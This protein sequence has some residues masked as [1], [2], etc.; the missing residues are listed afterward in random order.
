MAKFTKFFVNTKTGKVETIGATKVT[1]LDLRGN[2]LRVGSPT[3]PGT[4]ANFFVSGNLRSKLDNTGS[5]AVF[6][7]DVIV[8]G[9][10]TANLGLSGSLTNLSDGT[11][12]LVAGDNVTI[13]SSSN[14]NITI[15]GTSVS[16]GVI[17]KDLLSRESA[18]GTQTYTL[19]QAPDDGAATQVFVNGVLMLSASHGLTN[20]YDYNAGTNQIAFVSAPD[21][22]SI[23][24]AVY[25]TG[26]SGGGGGGGAWTKAGSTVRLTEISDLVGVGTASPEAKFEISDTLD[27]NDDLNDPSDYQL[28][29][30]HGSQTNDKSAGIG[31]TVETVAENIGAAIIHNRDGDYSQG[32]LQFYT[33]NS[34]SDAADPDLAMTITNAQKVGIGTASPGAKLE[35]EVADADNS[36]GVL[37]DSD[38]TGAHYALEVDAESTSNPAAYIHGYG[39]HLEQDITSGYGLKVSRNIAEGGSNPLVDIHDD[40]T[41]NTQTTLKVAQDGSGDLVNFLTGT[42]E[43][44]TI[45]NSGQLGVGTTSPN[46]KITIEGALS[47]DELAASPGTTSGYGKVFVKS[48]DSKLYFKNDSGTEFDLTA[49]AT[50]GAPTDAEYVVLSTD[51]GLSA[52]RVLTPGNG[53][54]LVD[55]GSGAAVTISQSINRDDFAFATGELNLAAQVVKSASADSGI[56]DGASHTLTFAGGEGIDTSAAGST[57]TIA[58]ENASTSNKGITSFAAADFTVISGHTS[59]AD[60]VL[61]TVTGDAGSAT[62]SGHNLNFIGGTNVA[63]TATGDTVTITSSP[64]TAEF[65]KELLS[66]DSTEGA[67]EYTLSNTPAVADQIQVY[68]NGMLRLSGSGNDYVYDSGDNQIDF[69]TPPPSGSIIQAIYTTAGS[70]S[71]AD[72]FFN[73]T[74]VGS[75]FTT[76]AAAFIGGR[77]S[78]S[79]IDAPSDKGNDVFFFVSGTI[80][81]K[82]TANTGSAL[83]GGDVTVSGTTTSESGFSGSLTRLSNGTSFLASAGTITITTSSTG[84]VTISTL[85][86]AGTNFFSSPA[87]GKINTTGSIIFRGAQKTPTTPDEANDIGTDTFF[88]VSGTLGARGTSN[89]GSAVFGGD[90]IFSGA[91]V[92]ELGLSGSLTRLSDGT[93]YLAAGENI[94]ITSTSNGQ[95]TITSTGGGTGISHFSSTTAGSIFTTGAVAFVGG[96]SSP[97]AIDAPSDIGNDVFFFVSGTI[98]SHATSNTGSAVF[99]GDVVIS[100]ALYGGSPLVVGDGLI[101]TGAINSTLGLSGSLTRLADGTSYLAAGSNVTITSSSNGQ[102]TIASSGGGGSITVKENDGDP[103]VSSVTTISFDNA[104]VTDAGSNTVVISGT[105]GTAEDGSYEDGLFT[106][107]TNKTYTGVA[108]D[109]I[110]EVL[111]LLAPSPAPDLDDVNAFETGTGVSLSFGSSNSVAG[112]TNVAGS[113]GV[114]AAVDVNGSYAVLT[115]SNNI[116]LAAFNH[117]QS[118]SGDLNADVATSFSGESI[119]NFVSRSFGNAEQGFLHLEVNGT[120]IATA[121][122]SGTTSDTVRGVLA[123]GSGSGRYLNT[124][125]SGFT[126]LSITGSSINND[127]SEF[128]FFQHRTGRFLVSTSSQRSGWNYARVLHV[129]DGS[130]LQT[131]YLEW[132]NDSNS[133]ALAAS[134]NSIS[135]EMSGSVHLSGVEYFTS[136]NVR[137]KV[138]VSNAYRNVYDTN[139]ITFTTTNCTIDSQAKP[140]IAGGEDHTK[141]LHLTGVGPIAQTML[142]TGSVTASVNVTHPFKANLSTAGVAEV[143]SILMFNLSGSS[144]LNR[145]IF[146]AE[147]YRIQSGAF[148]TQ[149]DVTDA[150]NAWNSTK[151]MTASNGGHTNGL[152]F[153]SASL[154]SPL[155][156]IFSGDFRNSTDGGSIST[157]PSEN[158]NYSGLTGSNTFYRYFRNTTGATHYT[159]K[160]NISGSSSTIVASDAALDSGKIRVFLKVPTGSAGKTGWLDL[161]SGFSFG[162]FEDNDGCRDGTFDSSLNASNF[163][164]FGNQGVANNEYIC[165]RIEASSSWAGQVDEFEVIFG[166]GTGTTQTAPI[167]SRINGQTAGVTSKLSFGSSK[168]ITGYTNVAASAGI[169]AAVDL[170]GT[171]QVATSSNNFRL[172]TFSGATPITGVLNQHVTAVSPS[173]AAL[174]FDQAKTGTLSLE[175]NGST[176]HSISLTGSIGAGSPGSGTGREVNPDGSGFIKLSE[177]DAAEFANGVSDFNK[178]FRTSNYVVAAASQ[179]NGWNYARVIHE[180][181]GTNR[182]TTYTE[183]VNDPDSN[184]LTGILQ[185]MDNFEGTQP[186]FQSG[187]AYFV[188]GNCSSSMKYAIGNSYLNVYSAESNAITVSTATNLDVHNVVVT[189]SGITDALTAGIQAAK[190]S[191]LTNANSETLPIFVTHSIHFAQTGST[192]GPFGGTAFSVTGSATVLHPLKSNVTTTAVAK[193]VFLVFTGT[194]TSDLHNNERFTTEAFRIQSGTYA[195]QSSVKAGSAKWDSATSMNDASALG[196]YAGMLVYNNQLISPLSGVLGGDYRNAADGGAIQAPT[197]NPNYSSL[198]IYHREYER[199]F[200]ND[201]T[202][203]APQ[204]TITLYGDATLVGRAGTNSGSLGNDKN[205]HCDVKIAGKTGYL[206]LARPSAGAGNTNDGDGGLS[207]DIDAT[208][209]ASGASNICTFNGVT[210]D[211]TVS[212]EEVVSIRIVSSAGFTGK[213]S[214]IQ[215]AYS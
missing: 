133:D 200:E 15:A 33:K 155:N 91:A 185:V 47:L 82:G 147:T 193:G 1:A 125:G 165:A 212:G 122:L 100:G 51:S 152:Q 149:S 156:T 96:Q 135:P 194:T 142:L 54:A 189:G 187:I 102:V 71:D 130:T 120:V 88:F 22:G 118:I 112:Y 206:D 39:T 58:G 205:I 173:Y 176:I 116:R 129:T 114:E 28:V 49:A 107:F 79:A 174:A 113:A 172:A 12:Y 115:S 163:A 7:G 17:F 65:H 14:G 24:Q 77:T 53:I 62:T 196:H 86:G 13:T 167:L 36:A 85:D 48:S 211:G 2:V 99:G 81:S 209:D 3:L 184:A 162:S 138:A 145:E 150:S 63:V 140:T 74:T 188:S 132:V 87:A 103:E 154:R 192:P 157:G 207:G 141:V 208:I 128:T 177:F 180:V 32:K 105:I 8:S 131:N 137:Y 44:A 197:G 110:N 67:L 4:D 89:T 104:I 42:T 45:D 97:T 94:T 179:R 80:G 92:A 75:I 60:S 210:L 55:S 190:P 111:K 109:R 52:E 73:S 56:A 70:A 123:P 126:N 204:I 46:E 29:V 175:V 183:W 151:H 195:N 59:L 34:T 121:S 108:I 19:T 213:I 84:Q 134:S 124:D 119:L 161:A 78:P 159:A 37:I 35:V 26:S 169:A 16:V 202:N 68:V 117:S 168:G 23:I 69:N 41:N 160:V 170:N 25:M 21:S 148:D 101:V 166:A 106:S 95:V 139:A 181:T 203:D 178:L 40:N 171:Y 30:R 27:P 6:G 38:E 64:S 146:E 18:A 11:S 83:F 164:N 214:R 43:V 158:P 98:G 31:F 50:A 201:T 215:V 127:G 10:L 199:Y 191:L 144:T 90:V 76:G 66:S 20:D 198:G 57:V 182:T 93:S 153:F 9:A 186:Y 5:L 72:D 61:K 136:G 143:S